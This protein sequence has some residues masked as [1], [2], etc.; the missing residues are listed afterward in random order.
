[1]DIRGTDGALDAILRITITLMC[2][3][4]TFVVSCYAL[5]V[6]FQ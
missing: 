4:G 3:L 5:S 1:M 2:V 6:I